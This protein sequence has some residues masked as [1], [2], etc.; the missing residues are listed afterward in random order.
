MQTANEQQR[1]D[2]ENQREGD[3]RDHQNAAHSEALASI[4]DSAAASFHQGSGVRAS[5]ADG[6][7]QSKEQASEDGQGSGKAEDSPIRTKVD[8]KR[9]VGGGEKPD[10]IAAQE[11][12]EQGTAG[13]S[14]SG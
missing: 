5:S 2:Q 3:L 1:A 9:V 4:G 13:R 10:Q 8:I 6:G 11:L 12:R 14:N 7:H